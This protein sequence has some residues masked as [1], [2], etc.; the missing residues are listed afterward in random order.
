MHYNGELVPLKKA[1][2]VDVKKSEG[3]AT[4]TFFQEI[5]SMDKRA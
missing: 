3:G 4:T 5:P 2:P 1:T